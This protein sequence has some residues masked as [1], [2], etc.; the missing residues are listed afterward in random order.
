M[1]IYPCTFDWIRSINLENNQ[2]IDLLDRLPQSGIGA[3]YVRTYEFGGDYY[4]AYFMLYDHDL[5]LLESFECSDEDSE[6]KK[7]V[8]WFIEYM[9]QN[10]RDAYLFTVY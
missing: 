1:D 5:E 4:H 2:P 7:V 9:K 10:P 3:L 8:Q 6:L